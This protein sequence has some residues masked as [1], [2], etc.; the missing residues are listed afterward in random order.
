MLAASQGVESHLKYSSD[1]RSPWLKRAQITS[2]MIDRNN[3]TMRA[4][5]C[6]PWRVYVA[7]IANKGMATCRTAGGKST[8]RHK[9][10]T[11]YHVKADTAA[12]TQASV[13]DVA[14]TLYAGA[15]PIELTIETTWQQTA[16][17]AKRRRWLAQHEIRH[18]Q[19][20]TSDRY[21]AASTRPAHPRH[22]M[23]NWVPACR[24]TRPG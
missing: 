15:G 13:R 16:A 5:T 12:W 14:R 7:T 17:N 9:Q 21:A 1:R 19:A 2:V 23:V 3:A 20:R 22:P 11:P 10:A 6:F 4:S 8:G 18:V 24:T